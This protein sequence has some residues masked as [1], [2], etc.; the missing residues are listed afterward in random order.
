MDIISTGMLANYSKNCTQR[1]PKNHHV[2][3]ILLS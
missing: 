1:S 2:F 3:I